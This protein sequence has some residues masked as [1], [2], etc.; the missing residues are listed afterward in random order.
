MFEL[1]QRKII[2]L[3]MIYTHLLIIIIHNGFIYLLHL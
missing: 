3:I 2:L 1:L